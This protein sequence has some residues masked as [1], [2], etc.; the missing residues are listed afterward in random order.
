MEKLLDVSQ[1][2]AMCIVNFWLLL[3]F[4]VVRIAADC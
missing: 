3:F 2:V 4:A 1:S